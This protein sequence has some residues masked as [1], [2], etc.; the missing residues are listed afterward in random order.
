MLSTEHKRTHF[1]PGPAPTASWP[2]R[3]V[4]AGN[5][6][7]TAERNGFLYQICKCLP[8]KHLPISVLSR[9]VQFRTVSYSFGQDWAESG[10]TGQLWAGPYRSVRLWAG[11]CRSVLLRPVGSRLVSGRV[12][13]GTGGRELHGWERF[14]KARSLVLSQASS[15][16]RR[17]VEIY[18]SISKPRLRATWPSTCSRRR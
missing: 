13:T 5:L 3:A 9:M 18:G 16:T 10:R 11:L 12:G 7:G 2:G 8:K 6:T 1:S 15:G 4:P 14:A 17:P